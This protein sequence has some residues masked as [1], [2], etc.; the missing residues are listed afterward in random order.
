MKGQVISLERKG[1][2]LTSTTKSQ[3]NRQ[4]LHSKNTI[5]YYSSIQNENKLKLFSIT[6]NLS[7]KMWSNCTK[8]DITITGDG[9][10]I[11]LDRPSHH[12][13]ASC[14]SYHYSSSATVILMF[15]MSLILISCIC[16]YL[17]RRKICR[18]QTT[19]DNNQ[20]IDRRGIND[21]W[22][23]GSNLFVINRVSIEQ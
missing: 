5:S 15:L 14:T 12:F 22:F 8:Y 13:N 11:R 16:C 19:I 23:H 18:V 20:P 6:T 2:R 17:F 10:V 7:Y 21:C 1:H 3:S 9:N 4:H